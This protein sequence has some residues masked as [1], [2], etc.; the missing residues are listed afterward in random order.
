MRK[1]KLIFCLTAALNLIILGCSKKKPMYSFPWY[2][3]ENCLENYKWAENKVLSI[4][5]DSLLLINGTKIK[6]QMEVRPLHCFGKGKYQLVTNYI[7]KDSLYYCFS[8]RY[9]GL[10]LSNDT[11]HYIIQNI[12]HLSNSDSIKSLIRF[13]QKYKIQENPIDLL[14]KFYFTSP[15]NIY[16][17]GITR[18]EIESLGFVFQSTS[19]NN[20]SDSYSLLVY[21][22]TL[23]ENRPYYS[24]CTSKVIAEFGVGYIE[25]QYIKK[26]N[27]L[28]LIYYN[29]DLTE[30]DVIIK[31][32]DSDEK[33][34]SRYQTYLKKTYG[35]KELYSP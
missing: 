21:P 5:P 17:C 34:I 19:K 18:Q 9:T 24:R 32:F 35:C 4:E 14:N 11:T 27:Y 10:F 16:R 33:A 7:S 23:D 20:S 12:T 29:K 28:T 30:Y 31:R 13:I 22:V 1:L 2:N 8:S 6:P 3:T 26:V 15:V 25:P